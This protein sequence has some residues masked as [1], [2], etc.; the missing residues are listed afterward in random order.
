MNWLF[1]R[2]QEPSS[3]NAMFLLAGMVGVNVAPALQVGI[4]TTVGGAAAVYNFVRKE[5]K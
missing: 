2:L 5:K 1:A 4:A 3:I